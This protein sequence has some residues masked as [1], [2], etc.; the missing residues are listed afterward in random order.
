MS[1]ATTYTRYEVLRTFRNFRFFIFSLAFP[2]ALYWALAAS[3]KNQKDF[4]GSGLSAPLYYML[5]LASFGTMSAVLASGARISAE[6][7]VGWNRQLRLT[8]L[9]VRTYFRTKVLTGYLMST[10]SL[11]LLYISG[12]ILG[13]RLDAGK[14]LEMTGLIFVALIPFAAMGIA[15]GH[16][17]SVDSMGP[18]IGGLTAF[19]AFFG[20]T[21]FPIT[22]S[23]FFPT[24]AQL[25][26]SYW[27]VQAGHVAAG[28]HAWTAK[29]WLVIAVWAVV[30]AL[31]AAR[32][33]Q[34]DTKRV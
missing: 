7:S 21:W 19:L 5:G 17:L 32:A 22:G 8:P 23:G 14:W 27:L 31:V 24:V 16:L 4:G 3:N 11:V 10:C 25:L 20:G 26:P 34:R 6:R 12:F 29:G 33:Y 13:V 15:L 18:A 30:G 9:S 2:L 1:A 28:A